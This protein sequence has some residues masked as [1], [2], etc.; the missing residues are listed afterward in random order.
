MGLMEYYIGTLQKSCLMEYYIGKMYSLNP[1]KHESYGKKK[2]PVFQTHIFI[3][4]QGQ[5]HM[6][7]WEKNGQRPGKSRKPWF[8]PPKNRDFVP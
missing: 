6:L 2:S 3:L 8:L 5:K 1:K 4:S 7:E